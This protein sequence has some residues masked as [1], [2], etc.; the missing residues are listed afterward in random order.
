MMT[1]V[2]IVRDPNFVRVA[3]ILRVPLRSAAWRS[4]HQINFWP[5]FDTFDR[6]TASAGFDRNDVLGAFG[7]LMRAIAS[8]DERLAYTEDDIAWFLGVLDGEYPQ[9]TIAMLKAFA[10]ASDVMVT[11]DELASI[12]GDGRSTW[13]LRAQRIPGAL[14]K[15]KTWLFPKSVLVAMNML[16]EEQ[17]KAFDGVNHDGVFGEINIEGN[18]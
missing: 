15:G 6:T 7:D 3:A 5:L 17:A 10:A 18:E 12:T 14:V 4:D 16:T 9:T 11:A 8:A 13:R 1:L 2:S